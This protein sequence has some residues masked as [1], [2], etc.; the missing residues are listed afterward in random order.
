MRMALNPLGE[1]LSIDLT[2][3]QPEKNLLLFIDTGVHLK[4]IQHEERFHRGMADSL[5]SVNERMIL[6]QRE[7]HR[8]RLFSE[9][10]IEFLAGKSHVRLCY[11]RFECAEIANA[12]RAARLL[13]QAPVQFENLVERK[14]ADHASRR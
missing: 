11:R 12:G 4:T 8:R 14:I 10:W 2:G 3:R 13:D 9:R 6:D 1:L 5:V 7:R